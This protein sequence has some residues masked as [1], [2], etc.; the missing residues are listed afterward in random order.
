MINIY[1][2]KYQI[3]LKYLKNTKANIC[4]VLVIARDFNIRDKE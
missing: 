4:N 1:S 3:A 2:D